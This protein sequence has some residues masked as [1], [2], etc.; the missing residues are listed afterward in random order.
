MQILNYDKTAVMHFSSD[1]DYWSLDT[2]HIIRNKINSSDS[3]KFLG[4]ILES[5]LTWGNILT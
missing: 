4:V 1:M 2:S 3:L 5:S